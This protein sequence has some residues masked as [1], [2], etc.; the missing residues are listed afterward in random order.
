M[1]VQSG[2]SAAGAGQRPSTGA[3][4]SLAGE[5]TVEGARH[6]QAGC[7]SYRST[8]WKGLRQRRSPEKTPGEAPAADKSWIAITLSDE[9]VMI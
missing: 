1:Q 6:R 5:Q 8:L 7:M 9:I 3:N 4:L 2:D